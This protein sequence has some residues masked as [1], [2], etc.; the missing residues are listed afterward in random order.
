MAEINH[1]AAPTG[2]LTDIVGT[3]ESAVRIYRSTFPASVPFSEEY[4]AAIEWLAENKPDVVVETIADPTMADP[5]VFLRVDTA[6]SAGPLLTP[7]AR[8][9]PL[10]D[11]SADQFD[12]FFDDQRQAT[13]VDE[14]LDPYNATPPGPDGTTLIDDWSRLN[15]T[16][17]AEV[18]GSKSRRWP[19]SCFTPTADDIC[20][21]VAEI[22]AKG[23]H[24]SIAG[25]R[26]SQG[27]Q[28]FGAGNVVL[29]ITDFDEILAFDRDAKTIVVQ[30]GITWDKI[31]RFIHPH[32]LSVEVMQAYPYF[33]VGG[34]LGVSVHDSDIRFGPLIETVNSFRI[35]L[36]D[37]RVLHVSRTEHPEV[38]G[39]AI[40][41][42]GLIGV[43]L[44]V[45]LQLTDDI[46]LQQGTPKLVPIEDFVSTFHEFFGREDVV[47]AYARPCFAHGEDFLKQVSIVD[48]TKVPSDDQPPTV[49]DI[50]TQQYVGLRKL[51]YDMS[52]KYSWAMEMRWQ[53]EAAYGDNFGGGVVSRNNQM[54]ADIRIP[55]DYRSPTDTDALQEYFIPT[56]R[57]AD[58]VVA[59]RTILTEHHVNVMSAGIRYVPRS[60]E[61]V[62]SYSRDADVFGIV[63]VFNHGTSPDEIDEVRSFTRSIIDAAIA[64]GGVYYL[65]YAGYAT[66]EQSRAAYPHLDEFF[67]KKR[68]YDAAGVFDST[69]SREY[70]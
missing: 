45:E 66:V 27:G 59:L 63:M 28:T 12:R 19:W 62:L 13:G 54:R 29:D 7:G 30:T 32:G 15:Q 22:A 42:L 43:I 35:A 10:P 50:A 49:W 17:V 46:L 16:A 67:A 68:D 60:S 6:V 18:V 58:F 65:P 8:W 51:I 52:R 70:G 31:Q 5:Y 47:N 3:A 39:L 37:S 64:H 23:G 24:L 11:V 1:A 9:L 36:S 14:H 38:F 56:D 25:R 53:L 21:L 4:A 33:T 2:T 55:G 69:F 34:S 44:D 61:S 40:G 26:H 48:F 20:T 41:G 57:F